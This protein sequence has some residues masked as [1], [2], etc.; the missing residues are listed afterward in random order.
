MPSDITDSTNAHPNAAK[1]PKTE[2]VK[3]NLNETE[4]HKNQEIKV[5]ADYEISNE[6]D[7][8]NDS[9]EEEEEEIHNVKL[10]VK[11]MC[12]F[13]IENDESST[14]ESPNKNQQ[15]VTEGPKPLVKKIFFGF[16][17]Y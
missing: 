15:R 2:N 6:N 14:Q 1:T 9:F 8:E 16:I 7:Y 4:N 10:D 11:I 12:C 5:S 3:F 17:K 13:P